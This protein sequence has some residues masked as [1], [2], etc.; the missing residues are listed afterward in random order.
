MTIQPKIDIKLAI[1]CLL[2]AAILVFCFSCNSTGETHARFEHTT[3]TLVMNNPVKT[4]YIGLYIDTYSKRPYHFKILEKINVKA[5]NVYRLKVGDYMYIDNDSNMVIR[6][7]L[8]TIRTLLFAFLY[9][10]ENPTT[11]VM[12]RDTI[13]IHDTIYRNKINH[14]ERAET[15]NIGQ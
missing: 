9:Q 7:S 6:D 15:V 14:I 5:E 3:D 1:I 13:Y 2:L 11:Y 8:Q 12:L 4:S 10:F